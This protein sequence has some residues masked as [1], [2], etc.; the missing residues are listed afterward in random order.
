[1]LLLPCTDSS[2][3]DFK[4]LWNLYCETFP[5]D[6][7]REQEQHQELL[8]RE[9]FN[10]SAVKVANEL[11]GFIEFWLVKRFAFIEHFAIV[12]KR[13]GQGIG[14]QAI[15]VLL[16]NLGR[17]VVLEVEPP[18]KSSE[19]ANRISFYERI[20]FKLNQFE[21]FQP[22]LGPGKKQ[23]A[24]F[25]MSHPVPIAPIDYAATLKTIYSEVYQYQGE[26]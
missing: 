20:G 26:A 22:P 21:Y 15:R 23:V 5:E 10:F 2:A 12:P 17:P 24:M 8:S 19:V 13:R 18:E 4:F 11:V 25:L 6:E 16:K 7:R 1:M 9:N 3:S 14:T